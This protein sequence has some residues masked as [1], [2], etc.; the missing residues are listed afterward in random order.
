MAPDEALIV[1]IR[2]R[3]GK[4]SI[5]CLVPIS[6]P[7]LGEIRIDESLFAG[8]RGS[9]IRRI[10]SRWRPRSH[11]VMRA[12]SPSRRGLY[13]GPGQQERDHGQRRDRGTAAGEIARWRRG[14]RF[15]AALCYRVRLA[16]R[17]PVQ[18]PEPI[19]VVLTLTPERDDL[20]LQPVELAGFPFLVSKADETFS[21]YKEVYPH[22]V[23]YA[24]RAVTRTFS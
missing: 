21:R 5:S 9:A 13:R 14:A 3:W 7:E 19:S 20:G 24:S 2:A 18:A 12:S 4:R 15:G 23:N 22:Q 8:P 11:A 1:E 17:T 10:S 16:S 6:H